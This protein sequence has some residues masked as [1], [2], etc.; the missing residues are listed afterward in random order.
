VPCQIFSALGMCKF[1]CH[2]DAHACRARIT[3]NVIESEIVPPWHVRLEVGKL[4]TKMTRVS[5]RCRLSLDEEQQLLEI[6]SMLK[7]KEAQT[8]WARWLDL[9]FSRLFF[10]VGLCFTGLESTL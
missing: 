4:I 8:K 6:V 5:A 1:D 10:S 3:L 2:P 7:S 9:L